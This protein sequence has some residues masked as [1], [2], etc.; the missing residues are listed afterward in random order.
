L[1]DGGSMLAANVR[2]LPLGWNSIIVSPATA[3]D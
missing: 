1:D 3:A 2:G